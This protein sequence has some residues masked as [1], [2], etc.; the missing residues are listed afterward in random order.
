MVCQF[1][2]SQYTGLYT[3]TKT[4]RQRRGRST[5]VGT[6]EMRVWMNMIENEYVFIHFRIDLQVQNI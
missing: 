6:H 2:L 1:G 3:R 4:D 5:N